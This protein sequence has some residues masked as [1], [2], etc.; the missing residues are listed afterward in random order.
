MLDLSGICLLG[1]CFLGIP[2]LYALCGTDLTIIRKQ[3]VIM[4]GYAVI[5]VLSFLLSNELVRH[6]GAMGAAVLYLLLM[7]VLAGS[8]GTALKREMQL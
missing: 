3:K 7:T 2:V 1:A 6:A 8:F 5:S 4:S